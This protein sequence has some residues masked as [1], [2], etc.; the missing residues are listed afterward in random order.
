L[1]KSCLGGLSTTSPEFILL[2]SNKMAWKSLGSSLSG[3]TLPQLKRMSKLKRIKGY[4]KLKKAVIVKNLVEYC[5]SVKVQK[6]Y[7][8]K[9]K[10][11]DLCPIS[12]EP[13]RWPSWPTRVS[14]GFIYYN[15]EDLATFLIVSGDFRDP[16]TREHFSESKLEQIDQF[17]KWSGLGVSQKTLDCFRNRRSYKKKKDLEEQ[18]DILVER[19]RYAAWMIREKLEKV[20]MGLAS[21]ANVFAQLEGGYFPEI[22]ECLRY[23]ENKSPHFL[24]IA[25]AD[26][27]KVVL[28][29]PYKC[30]ET[31]K[32]EKYFQEWVTAQQSR[33]S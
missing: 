19:I 15:L 30:E 24:K 33:F 22:E 8:R 9:K 26:A 5:A 3:Y 7:R 32:L 27:L 25:L 23:L 21:E 10:I 2:G 11:N 1:T 12:L 18:I 14:K 13:V 17:V 20:F 16:T 31:A 28:E 6:W 29:N 4:S